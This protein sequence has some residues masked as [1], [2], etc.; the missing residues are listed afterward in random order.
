MAG[1]RF[2]ILARWEGA[3]PY[4]DMWLRLK[5]E[6]AGGNALYTGNLSL[7]PDVRSL[8]WLDTMRLPPYLAGQSAL[9]G[10]NLVLYALRAQAGTHTVA[11]DFLQLSPISST[12]GWLRFVKVDGGE[13]IAYQEY[14]THDETEG[15]TYRTDTSSKIISEFATYGGPIMLIPNVDQRVYFLTCDDQGVSDIDQ[16]W[17]VKAWYRPRRN[18]L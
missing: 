17:T 11:L 12:G 3:F 6:G 9:K 1:G 5:L 8:H 7:I 15:Y 10:I 14:F 2:A 18:S 13:G 16:E 4:T